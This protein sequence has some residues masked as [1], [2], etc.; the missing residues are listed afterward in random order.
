MF[1][2]DWMT[3]KVYTVTQDDSVSSAIKL[4]K[5]KKVKH[6]PVVN[7]D[8]AVVGILSDRDI[9]DYT[10]SKASTFDIHELNYI[11]FTTKVKEIMVKKVIT[12]PPG[13]PV[14][15]AAMV[16]FDKDIGCL[17]VVDNGKLA[18]IIS[19]RDLFRVLVDITGVRN[20]GNRFYLTIKDKLGATKDVLD[21]VRDHGFTIDSVLTTYR[22][23]Q[24][25][26]K[27]VV[28]RTKG[29]NGDLNAVNKEFHD[30][31]GSNYYLKVSLY[32]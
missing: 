24:K 14:E 31:Y 17:P 20:G 10:P 32:I 28:V 2:S 22:G 18:G 11:L 5:E 8:N 26:L 6:L 29:K 13:T 16:M 30:R 4:L 3:K 19:D 15:E 1:V 23:V 21:I 27:K 7:K 25:G 9:K 12:T